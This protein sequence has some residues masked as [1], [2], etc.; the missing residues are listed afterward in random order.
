MEKPLELW[1]QKEPVPGYIL[2]PLSLAGLGAPPSLGC[3][4]NGV[5]Q[6]SDPS[7]ASEP[8]LVPLLRTWGLVPTG[9]HNDAATG[10]GRDPPPGSQAQDG[11]P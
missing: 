10:Y 4:I 2:R 9:C 1:Q 7:S 8:G 5:G 6:E 3:G 11:H